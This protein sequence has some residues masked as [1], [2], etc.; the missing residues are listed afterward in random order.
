MAFVP[1]GV[2]AVEQAGKQKK[3]IVEGLEKSETLQ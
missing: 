2:K 1:W 3:P